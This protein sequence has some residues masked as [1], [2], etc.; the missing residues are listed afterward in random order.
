MT[1]RVWAKTNYPSGWKI[2]KGLTLRAFFLKIHNP[3]TL[4]RQGPD[5]G[6]QYR[7]E[8]FYTNEKQKEIAQKILDE[9]DKEFN[10]KIVTKI[11]RELNYCKG[12]DYHQKYLKKRGM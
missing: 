5:I 2:S 4:N 6:T 8:I 10:G 12:E 9:S 7:S 3:T 1:V 11:S